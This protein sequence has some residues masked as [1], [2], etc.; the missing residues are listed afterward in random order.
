MSA[1]IVPSVWTAGGIQATTLL[2]FALQAVTVIGV[3]V[4]VGTGPESVFDWCS[5][6]R[7]CGAHKQEFG[8]GV[9]APAPTTTLDGKQESDGATVPV[10]NGV[11][12]L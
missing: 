11:E 3:S 7:L 1:L 10:H 6:H 2:C 4:L 5:G 8:T 12:A 9:G